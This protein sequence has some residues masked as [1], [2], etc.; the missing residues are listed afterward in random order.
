MTVTWSDLG[1]P[2]KPGRYAYQDCEVVVDPHA[3]QIWRKYPNAVFALRLTNLWDGT[4][5]GLVA[6]FWRSRLVRH[7][8]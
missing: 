8:G 6:K 2:T 5:R 1:K 7:S 3:I 4:R